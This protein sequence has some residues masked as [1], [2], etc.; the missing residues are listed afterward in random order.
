MTED[1]IRNAVG[2]LRL[3]KEAIQF[4]L[5]QTDNGRREVVRIVS[6]ELKDFLRGMDLTGELRSALVGLTL[7]V[8]ASIKIKDESAETE[9]H[10][11]VMDSPTKPEGR[12]AKKTTRKKRAG[13][14]APIAKIETE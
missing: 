6:D 1:G 8:N 3:P 12:S 2:D 4:L 11:T 9:I 14:S 5:T 10:S 7:E 13:K